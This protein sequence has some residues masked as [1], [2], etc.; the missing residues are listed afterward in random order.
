MSLPS[1]DV[2]PEAVV[3]Y[4]ELDARR[5]RVGP[6]A[7]AP[8]ERPAAQQPA[9]LPE[10]QLPA[11]RS[12]AA[13]QPTLHCGRC[14]RRS[15]TSAWPSRTS[16]RRSTLYSDTFGMPV[17]HRETVTEQGVEAVLLGVGESHVELLRAARRR[18]A[19]RQVPRQEGP[20]HPP[21]RLSLRRRRAGHRA[22]PLARPAADRRAAAARHPRQPRRVPPPRLDR[23]RADRAGAAGRGSA[24]T[25]RAT[26]A[27]SGASR[28]ASRAVR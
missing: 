15:I 9:E 16:T 21:H 24:L 2:Q 17:Q 13:D 19:G 20:R 3:D 18:Y 23:R 12:S 27:T 14:S 4:Q 7:C 11:G 10:P 6:A 5:G 8:P 25:W 22:V 28:S 1:V 26:T